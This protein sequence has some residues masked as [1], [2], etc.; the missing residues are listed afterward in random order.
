M[1]AL[2]RAL[3]EDRWAYAPDF[4]GFGDSDPPAAPPSISEYAASIGALLD[5]TGHSPVDVFGYHTGALSAVE[6]AIERPMQIR[7]LVLVGLPLLDDTERGALVAQPWPMPAQRDGSHLAVEWERS[8]HWA[9]PG[10]TFEMIARGFLDK[11]K[12][13]ERASW[14][15][16]AVAGYRL[17]ERLPLVRQPILAIGPRDDLW[18]VSPRCVGLIQHGWF[19]RWPENGF[20]LMDVA[21]A[22]LAARVRDHLDSPNGVTGPP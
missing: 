14:G 5:A 13:G 3:G 11:L 16:R 6:L 22:R 7:R 2:I 4:P 19:E 15:A 1:E 9:G 8:W 12:A 10:Q 18:E 21:T 20:G 17:V